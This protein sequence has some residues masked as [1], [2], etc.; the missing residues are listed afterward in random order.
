MQVQE[1]AT[2]HGIPVEKVLGTLEETGISGLKAES[3]LSDS[4][5]SKLERLLPPR[6]VRTTSAGSAVKVLR[7]S[8]AGAVVRRQTPTR[9][10]SEQHEG[11]GQTE[12][13][14]GKPG[15]KAA[16]KAGRSSGGAKSEGRRTQ[17]ESKARSLLRAKRLRESGIT[18]KK[19]EAEAPPEEAAVEAVAT[20][21]EPQ[22][23]EVK[24]EPVEAKPE[25]AKVEAKAPAKEA[26]K[27]EKPKPSKKTQKKDAK[28]QAKEKRKGEAE[29][30]E[31][32]EGGAAPNGEA[33]TKGSPAAP[34]KEGEVK[35]KKGG[36]GKR[37][38]QEELIEART[39]RESRAHERKV[40]ASILGQKKGKKQQY[41]RT[42]RERFAA[43]Q[44][45]LREEE[46][47]QATTLQIHE[48][49][50]VADVAH[51]LGVNPS[52]I[53][54][55]LL[56][57]G[58]IITVNQTLDQESIEL[59]ADEF[60]FEIERVNLMDVNPFE[61]FEDEEV[62]EATL[63]ARPPVVTVM[64]HVD[65][66]KTKLMDAIRSADVASGEAGGITQHIGAY[67]V[68]L[69]QGPICFLDTPGHEAFTAMRARGA[70]VTDVVVLVVAADDGVMPQ[71]KEAIA[72]ARAAGVPI[73]VA[74][75]KIDVPGAN[76]DRVKQQLAEADLIP[77]DWGGKTPTAEI[78]ALKKV[79]IEE[80]VDLI[81]LQAELLELKASES[82]RPKGTVVE[83]RL[84][85][86]RGVVTT[87]L[88]QDGTLRIGDAIVAGVHSGKVR[89]LMNDHGQRVDEAKPGMPVAIMGLSGAPVAGD[90]LRGVP[91]ERTARDLAAKLQ[92]IQRDREMAKMRHVT[93]ENLFAQIEEGSIKDLNLI[94]KADVQGSAE[95]VCE[96]L[97][98]IE[99]SKV[100]VNILHRGV[101]AVSESD[102]M[103]ASA[104]EAIVLA[105]NVPVPQDVA[106]IRDQEGVDV[107]TYNVIYDAIEDI[108]K[109]MLGLLEDER[110]EVVLGHFE[111]LKI[112]RSSKAGLVIGGMVTSGRLVKGA[113]VRVI[114]DER[115]AFDGK[116]ETLRRFKDDVSEVT[117]G[118]ECGV[119]I[120]N[121]QDLR[122]HDI[123]ECYQME[124]VAATL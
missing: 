80:L 57:L 96:S 124:S 101:G 35:K 12:R 34:P 37:A 28:P 2:R 81:H 9:G 30:T 122:E 48:A 116:L 52:E 41:K 36:K 45:A 3:N 10:S 100:K 7:P 87:A 110:R 49:T 83:A 120:E 111:V 92:Q 104:S 76:V 25:P 71:T 118:L 58:R 121:F 82:K 38:K 20:P 98:G 113:K 26:P 67:Y 119:G 6:R 103:L 97:M 91:D 74:I 78:S 86:G 60:G 43:S 108:K 5:V 88:I 33:D 63:V 61:E 73:L 44:E 102:I 14:E 53:L 117:E 109:A 15:D 47:R 69:E 21:A 79:G 50:T 114:R 22:V 4:D 59:I 106:P 32:E 94:V 39:E 107:R 89:A 65:H 13:A 62:D 93:L 8:Q 55:I 31:K 19:H 54:K 18:R 90:E 77:E 64:G 68:A 17:A 1:L 84:E 51:G 85:Q 105:F 123:L 23:Q 40:L 42:K 66:G 16:G 29:A 95:A 112:F 99:S 72:H 75:N 11:A 70:M 56:D 115:I 46:A 27:S 24:P